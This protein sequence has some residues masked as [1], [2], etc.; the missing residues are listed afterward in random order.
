MVN[1]GNKKNNPVGNENITPMN[2]THSVQ[3]TNIKFKRYIGYDNPQE[4]K[5]FLN[6]LVS[7]AQ[8]D[9]IF[10]DKTIPNP[11][12]PEVSLFMSDMSAEIT[13]EY[14]SSLVGKVDF[15]KIGSSHNEPEKVF[16]EV[17]EEIKKTGAGQN[18]IRNAL[19]KFLCWCKRYSASSVSNI[20]YIGEISKY[21][22]YWLSIMARL[23][24]EVNYI[25][26]LGDTSYLETD[27][28]SLYSELVQGSINTPI[29]LNFNSADIQNQQRINNLLAQPISLTV[30]VST[31]ILREN[32]ETEILKEYS[33]RSINFGNCFD[34]GKISVYFT[35]FIGYREESEYK[36]FLFNLRE[37]LI[38]K[39]KKTLIFAES[40]KKP[41]YNEGAVFLSVNRTNVQLMI[42]QLAEKIDI[43]NCPARTVLARKNFIEVLQKKAQTETNTQ[44]IF[45]L[46]VN[47]II[48]LNLCTKHADFKTDIPV[49]MYYG[50]ITENEYTFLKMLCQIGF[51]I[52]Y[53]SSDKSVS[54]LIKN[55]N[56]GIVQIFESSLSCEPFPYPDKPVRMKLAT[57]AY[58][59][60]RELDTL[61]YN[62]GNI[63]RSRQFSTCRSVTLKTTYEEIDIL[64][65]YEAKYRTGF[66]SDNNIVTVPNIFAKISGTGEHITEYWRSVA[67]KIV[68]NATLIYTS[69]P[70]FIPQGADDYSAYFKNNVIDIPKLMKSPHNRYNYL[71]DNIQMFIFSKMQ[72]AIDSGIINLPYNDIVH[73][74]I[75]TGLSFDNG[76][77]RVIQ[78]YDFTKT[79][80]KIIV[81]HNIQKTFNV[82]EC[83][84][85]VLLNLMGFDIVI[86]TPTGYKNLENFVNPQGYENYTLPYFRDNLSIPNLYNFKSSNRKFGFFK[87]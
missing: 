5:E 53:I 14:I 4:F 87:W 34:S 51:D 1:F 75:K 57:N 67:N 27:P 23:G 16:S 62:D 71:N 41:S 30:D 52:I 13:Q 20:L 21:E 82:Y 63:F 29:N 42:S 36:N 22:V 76:M 86:Y 45:S 11:S 59:A 60:E 58:N 39:S 80:P 38:N 79:V 18:F 50:K 32:F 3:T 10:I 25:C 33:Q 19:I 35:A 12:N 64:W 74:V 31:P 47:M 70:F 44:R 6:S 46:G 68:D 69:L 65:K 49:V 73:L 26:F 81:V 78:N 55:G 24:C 17:I 2:E 56:D 9:G 28:M 83:I 85:L 37:S 66:S 40:F 54:E 72:E 8:K 15:S 84:Y 7:K 48:W 77:I 61:M 43:P